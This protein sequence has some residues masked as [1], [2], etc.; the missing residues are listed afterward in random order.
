MKVMEIKK[1]SQLI[2]EGNIITVLKDDVIIK[3]SGRIAHREVVHHP[4]GV[5]MLAIMND[6][7]LLI[8]QYRYVMGKELY[9]IPAGKVEDLEDLE[10]AAHRELEE[11]TGFQCQTLKKICAM[12]PSP[13]FL[14]EE[15]TIYEA[16]GLYQQDHPLAMDEDE[17]ITVCRMSL[18]K[19]YALVMNGEISDGKTIIAIQHAM[20]HRK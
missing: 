13:G 11:E 20:L 12:L 10:L 1:Q 4:R 5:G 17:R 9:E 3:D 2:Y 7:V 6:E 14:D 19:A 18:D 16:S 15:V 8:K